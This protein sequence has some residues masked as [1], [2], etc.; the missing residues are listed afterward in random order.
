MLFTKRLE[1]TVSVTGLTEVF[2]TDTFP[3]VVRVEALTVFD[4]VKGP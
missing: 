1:P 3:K 4:P 2:A